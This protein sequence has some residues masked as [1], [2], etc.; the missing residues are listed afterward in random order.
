MVSK[1]FGRFG[2]LRDSASHIWMGAVSPAPRRA[3]TWARFSPACLRPVKK[4]AI[5][6]PCC[7]DT[8][9]EVNCPVRRRGSEASSSTSALRG[10]ARASARIFIAV[11]SL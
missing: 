9:P 11:S 3:N 7:V 8:I 4:S 1:G 10:L 6:W 2:K 5:R